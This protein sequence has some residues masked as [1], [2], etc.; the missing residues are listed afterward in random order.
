MQQRPKHLTFYSLTNNIFFMHK[1]TISLLL[2]V[3][4][5]AFPAFTFAKGPKFAEQEEFLPDQ[6]GLSQFFY[7]F[8]DEK[9][10]TRVDVSVNSHWTPTQEQLENA[11]KIYV[12]PTVVGMSNHFAAIIVGGTQF[13]RYP[14]GIVYYLGPV[15]T[16]LPD[17]TQSGNRW[18][19]VG[20]NVW[21][22][23]ETAFVIANGVVP[24][25]QILKTW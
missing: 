5:S 1:L 23:L 14:N 19:G 6:P 21:V 4:V 22:D 2:L 17:W 13:R 11:P 25:R 16:P 7:W 20:D 10:V 18:V 3:M 9:V 24:V 15:S 8:H 12:G